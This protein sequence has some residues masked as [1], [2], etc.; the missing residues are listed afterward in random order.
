MKKT[1]LTTAYNIYNDRINAAIKKYGVDIEKLNFKEFANSIAIKKEVAK[2]NNKHY[3]GNLRS[4]ISIAQTSI[5]VGPSSKQA[6]AM[7]KAMINIGMVDVPS[8][9]KLRI[10]GMPKELEDALDYAKSQHKGLST[11]VIN[12]LIGQEIYGSL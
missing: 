9:S 3:Q 11:Y 5:F 2:K 7:R 10:I 4:A 6:K 12:Q 8:I 1:S